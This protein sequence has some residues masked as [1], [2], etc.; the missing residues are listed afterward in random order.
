MPENVQTLS[1]TR[2][3][4][5]MVEAGHET[6]EILTA[7]FVEVNASNEAQY[8]VTHFS[9]VTSG[10][11]QNHVFVDIDLQGDTRLLFNPIEEGELH[12]RRTAEEIAADGETED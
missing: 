1:L 3:N 2:I 6:I 8:Q 10:N 9:P 11:V 4:E 12:L 7:T 5:L